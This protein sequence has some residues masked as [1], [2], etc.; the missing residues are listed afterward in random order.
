MFLL[1][2]SHLLPYFSIILLHHTPPSYFSHTSPIRLPSSPILLHHTSNAILHRFSRPRFKIR[3][4][5]SHSTKHLHAVVCAT[6]TPRPHPVQVLSQS[7]LEMHNG[8]NKVLRSRCHHD[9]D[10]DAFTNYAL[11][12]ILALSLLC[13]L[14]YVASRVRNSL[15]LASA[16]LC[17][18]L[19]RP[20]ASHSTIHSTYSFAWVMALP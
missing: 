6:H 8:Y 18:L 2:F 10:V 13:L 12:C 1:Y 16:V 3:L 20:A 7:H 9:T 14:R 4:I 5:W 15:L 17:S 19:F 11:F